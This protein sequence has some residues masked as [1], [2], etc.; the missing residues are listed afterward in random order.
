MRLHNS[1]STCWPF[2]TAFTFFATDTSACMVDMA[3]PVLIGRSDLVVVGTVTA[4]GKKG[5]GQIKIA[6]MKQPLKS[7]FHKT[8]FKIEKVLHIRGGKATAGSTISITSLAKKPQKP[9]GLLLAVSDGPSY[10]NLAK[11]QKYLLILQR[12]QAGKGYYLPAYP[13]NFVP[14]KNSRAGRVEEYEKICNIDTWPWGEASNGIQLAVIPTKTDVTLMKSRKGRNGPFFW[15]AYTQ[16][17]YALRNASE[18]PVAINH[19]PVD[20]FMELKLK[21]GGKEELLDM[22]SFLARAKQAGFT[23]KN[24]TVVQPGGIMF[25]APYGVDQYG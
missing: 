4:V 15:N 6:T 20:R 17:V 11:G 8:G 5:N 16:I 10:P 13:K 22:W 19:Y 14:F 18:K 1:L 7:Y 2:L 21:Q 3:L 24:A 9:G 12:D 25:I 23:E